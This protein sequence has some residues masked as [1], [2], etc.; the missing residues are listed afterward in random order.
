MSNYNFFVGVRFASGNKS[1]CFGT[2][3]ET[4]KVDESVVVETAKGREMCI[5]TQ[6]STNISELKQQLD[7]KP[8]IRKASEKDKTNQ[9][10]NQDLAKEAMEICKSQ[11]EELKLDMDLVSAEYTLDRSKLSFVYVAD[12][13][14]D[15]RELLKVLARIFKCRIDLRQIGV[16]DKAKLIGGIGIC[17]K[18]TCC[19]RFKTNFD[20]ISINLAKNQMLALNVQKLSGQCGK[21]MCCLKYE[22]EAYTEL[23]KGMPKLNSYITYE[24]NKYKI[25]SINAISSLCKLDSDNSS[26]YVSMDDLRSKGKY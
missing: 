22:D 23:K 21:L 9:K 11:I 5:V 24:N 3:D 10:C 12:D 17:G 1:Y 20:V 15:F 7:L 19:S 6:S 26:I 13:R 4:I 25:T 18:E 8:V 16:R 2:N 14:V